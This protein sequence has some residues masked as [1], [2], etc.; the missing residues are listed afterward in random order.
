MVPWA[1]AGYG[2]DSA[3]G[4]AVIGAE[5][6][7]QALMIGFIDASYFFA[8]TAFVALPIVFLVKLRK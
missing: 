6:R 2:V 8:A 4:V 5:V 1:G 3:A 7:R